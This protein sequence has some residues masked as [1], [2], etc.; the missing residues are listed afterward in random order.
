MTPQL[1]SVH[2]HCVIRLDFPPRHHTDYD[3][4][5]Q[6]SHPHLHR[7]VQPPHSIRCQ[8]AR[9]GQSV[10]SRTRRCTLRVHPDA[11]VVH[12][13]TIRTH[14]QCHYSLRTS[15][16]LAGRAHHQ[17]RRVCG[18]VVLG[19]LASRLGVYTGMGVQVLAL[20]PQVAVVKVWSARHRR[21]RGRFPG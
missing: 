15:L 8:R 16:L 3:I 19:R 17:C 1:Y 5:H 11:T 21:A 18:Q 14:Q 20:L 2:D 9:I 10:S 6:P 13:T 4:T 12:A 7:P